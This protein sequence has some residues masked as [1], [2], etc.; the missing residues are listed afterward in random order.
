LVVVGSLINHI[1][2]GPFRLSL[3]WAY[4]EQLMQINKLLFIIHELVKVVYEKTTYED[5]AFVSENLWINIKT[6]LFA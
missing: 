5:K 6:Y 1:T 2:Y 3:F 4:A